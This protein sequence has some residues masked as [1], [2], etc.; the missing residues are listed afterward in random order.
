MRCFL[1]RSRALTILSLRSTRI[2]SRRFSRQ[3]S[4]GLRQSPPDV[5]AIERVLQPNFLGSSLRPAESRVVRPGPAIE[6]RRN[7]FKA[8]G[9]ARARSIS[10][11]HALR[12]ERLLE[13][14]YG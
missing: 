9:C 7:S 2:K 10:T 12:P 3:W 11:R 5:R 13:D 14:C 8:Q 4:A 6:V 1:K